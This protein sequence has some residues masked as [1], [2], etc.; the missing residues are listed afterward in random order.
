MLTLVVSGVYAEGENFETTQ[1]REGL[2][3][4]GKVSQKSKT[5][6]S[7]K[8][9]GSCTLCTVNTNNVKDNSQTVS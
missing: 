9:I 1:H 8:K 4:A 5:M 2:G 7:Q 6:K 3:E